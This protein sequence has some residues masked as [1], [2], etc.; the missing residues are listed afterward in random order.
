MEQA[1]DAKNAPLECRDL[2]TMPRASIAK[3]DLLRA[4]TL[5]RIVSDALLER[6]PTKTGQ[7]ARYALAIRTPSGVS[8]NALRAAM[9]DFQIQERQCASHA[10]L[11]TLWTKQVSNA[12]HAIP[13]RFD[14]TSIQNA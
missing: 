2:K 12:S 8:M 14:L 9:E 6:F 1:R 11:A 5:L 7:R 10:S 13:D 3:L 4:K